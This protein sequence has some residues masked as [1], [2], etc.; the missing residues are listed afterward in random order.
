M[1]KLISLILFMIN[2]YIVNGNEVSQLNI[3]IP[4]DTKP[5]SFINNNE[6]D[7]II[8]DFWNILGER[9]NLKINFIKTR[10]QDMKKIIKNEEIDGLAYYLYDKELAKNYIFSDIIYQ[11]GINAYYLNKLDF[12]LKK[13]RIGILNNAFLKNYFIYSKKVKIYETA[14]EMIKDLKNE[15]I[16]G[17]ILSDLEIKNVLDNFNNKL[18]LKKLEN[19]KLSLGYRILLKNKKLEEMIKKSLNELKISDIKSLKEK[20]KIDLDKIFFNKKE[21]EELKKSKKIDVLVKKDFPPYSFKNNF[22]EYD[23]MFIEIFEKIEKETPL[24]FYYL[25]SYTKKDEIELEL[26]FDYSNNSNGIISSKMSMV[27]N[28]NTNEINENTLKNKKIVIEKNNKKLKKI[29]ELYK[30]NIDIKEVKNIYDALSLVNANKDYVYIGNNLTIN[31]ILKNNILKNI[32]IIKY[33]L[34]KYLNITIESNDK[35]LKELIEKL[36]LNQSREFKEELLREYS[37]KN[38]IYFLLNE[39]E[40]NN[41]KTVKT[42]KIGSLVKNIENNEYKIIKEYFEKLFSNIGIKYSIEDIHEGEN[43]EKYDI[44]INSNKILNEENFFSKKVLYKDNPLFLVGNRYLVNNINLN[45]EKIA[46]LKDYKIEKELKIK[47]PNLKIVLVNNIEEMLELVKKKEIDFF[48]IDKINYLEKIKNQNFK[49][50]LILEER[51]PIFY[52]ISKKD[53]LLDSVLS[54]AVFSLEDEIKKEIYSNYELKNNNLSHQTD[55]YYI[56]VIIFLSFFIF[57]F[58]IYLLI[59]NKKLI[60]FQKEINEL[61]NYERLLKFTP[62]GL[63][64]IDDEKIIHYLNDE[65][66]K[67]TGYYKE[68]LIG[69]FFREV[70]IDKNIFNV[71]NE[72]LTIGFLSGEH[73]QEIDFLTAKGE[74]KWLKIHMKRVSNMY[75]AIYIFDITSEKEVEKETKYQIAIEKLFADISTHI[76]IYTRKN[77]DKEIRYGL[78]KLGEFIDVDRAYLF[79]FSKSKQHIYNHYEWRKKGIDSNIDILKGVFPFSYFMENFEKFRNIYITNINKMEKG[80]EKEYL[81]QANIKSLLCV[82]IRYGNELMGFVACDTVNKNKVWSKEDMSVLK[83]FGDI[84]ANAIVRK[85]MEER[86]KEAKKKAE[87]ANKA[88]SSFLA[89]MSHEIRTP[90]N[91][92]IGITHLLMN[93]TLTR[94]QIDYVKKVEQASNNL[95]GIINDILDFS[96]IEASKL[97]L[98]NTEFNIN[99]ILE[100]ISNILSIKLQNKKLEIIIEKHLD[101]PDYVVGDPTRVGQILLNLSNNAIKFTESGEVNIRIKKEKEYGEFLILKFEVEDTGIGIDEKYLNELFSPF[102]QEDTSITRK[103]GGTGLGLTI[104]KRLVELMGGKIFVE[105]EKNKGTKFTFTIRFLKSFRKKTDYVLPSINLEEIGVLLFEKNINIAKVL[106]MYLKRFRFKIDTAINDEEFFI[107]IKESNYKLIIIEYD[108]IKNIS[109]KILKNIKN[110]NKELKILCLMNYNE[111]LEYQKN[112]TLKIE[113]DDILLKPITESTIFDS[114]INIFEKFKKHNKI[115]KSTYIANGVNVLLAEDNEINQ[116]VAKEILEKKGFMVDVVDNGKKV[117]EKVTENKYDII[118]MDL[119]MPIM[120]GIEATRELRLIG[121]DIPIIALTA[122]A[123]SGVKEKCIAAGMNGYISKPI[124][125]EKMI[126][127][128]SN[129]VG[130]DKILKIDDI[131]LEKNIKKEIEIDFKYLNY[132]EGIKR[133]GN[134]KL[135]KDILEKFI[136]NNFNTELEL[137]REYNTNNFKN[138]SKLIHTLKGVSAN[139]SANKLSNICKEVESSIKEK[140]PNK[141]KENFEE[142]LEIYE[143]TYK[144]IENYLEKEK[145][146]EDE[147]PKEKINNYE[148]LIKMLEEEDMDAVDYFESID[149]GEF[150]KNEINLIKVL[151]NNYE[152]DKALEKLKKILTISR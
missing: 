48:I 89:N 9:N 67:I 51:Y 24:K 133:I 53:K 114:I 84:F 143:K 122:D 59:F 17:I 50:E 37:L 73:K 131:D 136:K 103:Y 40:I 13:D 148:K 46:I 49:I 97:T 10:F 105:S 118:L 29:K 34:I 138:L 152:F 145:E 129:W 83:I 32:K 52:Y 120:D 134:L 126:K 150:D 127:I 100:N 106:T 16:D 68:D 90:M 82:P 75:I 3:A 19:F 104:S 22:G 112:N 93:T 125:P 99:K 30:K 7:G 110:K 23:G 77:I 113:V 20:W 4:V 102:T 147:K 123:I 14:E 116:V 142:F 151:I 56:L 132:V 149:F 78:E 76:V 137:K 36:I 33:D 41:L 35:K 65:F 72:Q 70:I 140:N 58:I 8:V 55:K 11:L 141:L 21:V 94:K 121:V 85:E 63:I 61:K 74:K 101:V 95:L 87:L 54:K 43:I 135:Y 12:D 107:Y 27:V 115:V 1:K 26:D 5:F 119:Q 62:I 128:I 6:L 2:I 80:I 44:I 88:K 18:E 25:N 45:N 79:L 124:V 39:Y 130:K 91:A 71:I 108:L 109:K 98:E 38:N 57:I 92:I 144:E 139:I 117:I 28:E 81:L 15:K 47:Y 31:N 96:K 42:I 111:S 69:R 66:E 146:K 64:L 86:L 60:L